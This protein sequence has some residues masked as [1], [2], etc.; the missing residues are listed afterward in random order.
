MN[1]FG[2]EEDVIKGMCVLYQVKAPLLF[3]GE[4]MFG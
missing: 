2:A 4:L 3:H 1:L